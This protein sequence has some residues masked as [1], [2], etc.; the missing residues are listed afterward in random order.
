MGAEIV[1]Y[2]QIDDI[3]DVVTENDI[4]L[5]YID[6]TQAILGKF[7]VIPVCQDYPDELK[8]FYQLSKGFGWMWYLP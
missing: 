3:Y 6:Q 8:R 5:D 1:K 2:H 7:G 4:V